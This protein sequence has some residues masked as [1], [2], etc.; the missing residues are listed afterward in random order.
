V[1]TVGQRSTKQRTIVVEALD[2]CEDFRTAQDLHELIGESG[3]TVGLA[4]VYRTLQ[5]LV[6]ADVVDVIS[7]ADGE[8]LYRKCSES[9]HHH[10]VCRNCGLTIEV[11][12][13]A[14][15]KWSARM[16]KEHGFT[17]MSHTLEI[18]GLCANCS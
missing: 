13:P 18:F 15:E 4:T 3:K 8:T 12:G 17:D 10:L 9:H 11:S 5:A 2:H 7:R 16:A 14:V 1:S 6:E